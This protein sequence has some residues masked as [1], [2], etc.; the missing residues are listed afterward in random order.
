MPRNNPNAI[1][2]Q[3]RRKH[4]SVT[5]RF[6]WPWSDHL[7]RATAALHPNASDE[8]GRLYWTCEF[9]RHKPHRNHGLD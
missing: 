6:H 7:A 9:M 1:I 5:V 4:V 8:A 2:H 3:A